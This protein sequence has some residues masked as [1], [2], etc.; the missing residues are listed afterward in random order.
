M[1]RNRV[2][3]ALTLVV[4]AAA[5]GAA[6]RRSSRV[7][8][9]LDQTRAEVAQL[10][11]GFERLA[12]RDVTERALQ[13]AFPVGVPPAAQAA[14]APA[15]PA[16]VPRPPLG[17]DEQQLRYERRAE[18]CRTTHAGEVRDPAWS[19]TAAQVLRD[20][21]SGEA[22]RDVQLA[23]DCRSTMCRIDFAFS[24]PDAGHR[25]LRAVLASPAWNGKR[26][27]HLDNETNAGF[28]YVSRPG[29]ELPAPPPAT[30]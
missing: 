26:F 3:L 2:A 29:R 15:S 17:R 1:S 7:Q 16:P 25:A 14:P 21:Y 28:C 22:F 24:D 9:D 23:V 4:G 30:I 10:R 19:E 27:Y 6:V 12:D 11:A 8:R 13:Q 18:L 5:V 20:K